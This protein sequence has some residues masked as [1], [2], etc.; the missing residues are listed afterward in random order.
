M[1]MTTLVKPKI[2]S[3]QMAKC[4]PKNER[5]PQAEYPHAQGRH[6]LPPYVVL[7]VWSRIRVGIRDP[8]E[9]R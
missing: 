6:A 5:L 9:A 4:L 7:G 2:A 3:R 8:G 1:N